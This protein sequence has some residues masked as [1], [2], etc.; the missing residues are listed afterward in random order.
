MKTEVASNADRI[1]AMS[2]EELAGIV[3]CH[4]NGCDRSDGD[5]YSCSL[6]WLKRKAEVE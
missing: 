6:D 2:D 3:M 5:C 1:R 4:K